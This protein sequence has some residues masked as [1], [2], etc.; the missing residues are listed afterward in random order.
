MTNPFLAAVA[1]PPIGQ[2]ALWAAG[3]DG[4]HGPLINLSQAVPGEAPPAAMLAKLAECAGTG[5]A[6]RYGPILGDTAL[7]NAYAAHVSALY[8]TTII[9]EET[10]ISAG[11]NQAFFVAMMTVARTGDAVIL[12]TPSYFNH[13]MTLDMLGIETRALTTRAETGFLPDPAELE[14]LIDG[15]VRAVALVSPNNPTGAIYPPALIADIFAICREH[16]IYLILDETYRDFMPATG[17]APHGLFQLDGWRETLVC[18]Y[19]F[20]KSYA[21][22]GHRMGALTGSVAFLAEAEKVLDCMQ[23]C[24]PR[25]PQPALVWAIDA[26]ADWRAEKR[27][28][29]LDRADAFRATLADHPDWR[30]EQVGAYF[31]YV[32]HPFTGTPSSIVAERLARELGVVTLPGSFFGACQDG[33][34]R[35]AFANVSAERIASLGE[36]LVKAR[37]LFAGRT[38]QTAEA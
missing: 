11:C 31:A 14:A 12:P 6:A 32:R 3:Y 9:P 23:I 37:S 33:H 18:L 19:S 20:S 10:G 15:K 13:T 35:I 17:S 34:L 27:A 5:D 7:R 24:A 26:L 36:R 2:A 29:I 28:E 8:C 22:P 30:I 4:S 21:I 1:A 25:P 38:L 16:G